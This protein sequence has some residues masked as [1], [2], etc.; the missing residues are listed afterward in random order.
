MKYGTK[1][2]VNEDY[3]QS[4]NSLFH[5]MTSSKYL[6]DALKRKALCPR[7]C[8]E[9]ISYLKLKNDG[10]NFKE[11]A[12]LQKCFCDIPLHNVVKEFIVQQ[13]NNNHLTENQKTSIPKTLSHTRLYGEYA[14]AFTKRWGENNNLQPI[15][16]LNTESDFAKKFSDMFSKA[17]NE[18][19]LS[20]YVADTMLNLICYSKPLRGS[21]SRYLTNDSGKFSYKLIKNFHDEHEWRY[22]P[23]GLKVDENYVDCVSTSIAWQPT[24]MREIND[25]IE[26]SSNK[27]IWLN[28]EYE[29]LKYIIVPDNNGRIE[30]IET[31]QSLDDDYFNGDNVTIKKGVLTSKILVLSDILKDV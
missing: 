28:F 19:D 20:D 12:V 15:H 17:V 29:D 1:E 11:V 13:D 7:Y 14:L 2:F 4:A 21:M 27:E 5:F 30:V 8:N 31:I 22:V 25:R 26:D 10:I 6:T 24:L 9:D 23:F 18:D 3:I 16:Y